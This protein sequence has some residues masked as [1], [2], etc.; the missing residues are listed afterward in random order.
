MRVEG[1]G[2]SLRAPHRRGM[3]ALPRA[4]RLEAVEVV[5]AEAS[6]GVQREAGVREDHLRLRLVV[7]VEHHL[8]RQ[9]SDRLVLQRTKFRQPGAKIFQ[10]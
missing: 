9:S 10:K 2:E 6:E 4:D 1:A 3:L 8:L 7:E 5:P